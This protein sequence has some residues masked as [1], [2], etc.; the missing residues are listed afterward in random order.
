MDRIFLDAL[1][2]DSQGASA[3]PRRIADLLLH[4]RYMTVVLKNTFRLRPFF[5]LK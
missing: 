2:R 1:A 4:E 5:W 3:R